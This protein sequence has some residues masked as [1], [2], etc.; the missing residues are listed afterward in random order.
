LALTLKEQ[1][2]AF[3]DRIEKELRQQARTDVLTG[4]ANRRY[5]LDRLDEEIKRV[6]RYGG[7]LA[8]AILDVDHF[9][10]INDTYGHAAGDDALRVLTSTIE[11][12]LRDTDLVGRLGGEEFGVMLPGTG[13][14]GALEVAERI[15][16]DVEAI[17][18]HYMG[19]RIPITI[20]VG[21][22]LVG[23]GETVDTLSAKAD[24]M[25][26]QAKKNGRNRVEALPL[27]ALPVT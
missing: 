9:K 24:E 7:E 14:S 15:R 16:T 26:Y 5:F 22:A 27:S 4:I 17:D 19:V 13:L 1:E 11:D 20:S 18:F 6:R 2:L 25:L 12:S 23:E 3:R 10:K 21:V 8:L